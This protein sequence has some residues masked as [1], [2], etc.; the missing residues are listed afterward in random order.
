MEDYLSGIHSTFIPAYR[1]VKAELIS[2]NPEDE[3]IGFLVDWVK[4]RGVKIHESRCFGFDVPVSDE[5]KTAGK[6][7]Y[8]YWISVPETIKPSDKVS[9]V[10][11]DGGDYIYMR[12]KEPFDNPF[13]RITK[14]WKALVEYVKE[15]KIQPDWCSIGGCLEEVIEIDGVTFMDILIR[16]K[17]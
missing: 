2:A 4:S 12:I 5:E 14:G 10:D 1:M 3:V 9:I 6:R 16:L 11:F 7:G 13:D 17:K 15:N 8:E